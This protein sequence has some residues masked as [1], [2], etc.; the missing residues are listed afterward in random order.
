M[1]DVQ[2]VCL[3][4][5]VKHLTKYDPLHSSCPRRSQ[6]GMILFGVSNKYIA[7]AA[8]TRFC[9]TTSM[10]T[11]A[12]PRRS[13]TTMA[14]QAWQAHRGGVHVRHCRRWIRRFGVFG[15]K[16]HDDLG[17]QRSST[18]RGFGGLGTTMAVRWFQ[19]L[20]LRFSL[21]ADKLIA[22]ALDIARTDLKVTLSN[23]KL[24]GRS[25]AKVACGMWDH[26]GSGRVR[27][28]QGIVF[29]LKS[30]GS[31]ELR[32]SRHGTT[33]HLMSWSQNS[34]NYFS[35]PLLSCAIHTYIRHN[36]HTYIYIYVH[37]L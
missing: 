14:W 33:D 31:M 7:L 37:I 29:T 12:Y 4:P 36:R 21:S 24:Q 11:C 32:W 3:H 19:V 10:S 17:P 23:E 1:D 18:R 26:V 30:W 28:C 13:C 9:F 27:A 25:M 20:S 34:S 2:H 35:Q 16:G 5:G 6:L 8:S 22:D 15:Q